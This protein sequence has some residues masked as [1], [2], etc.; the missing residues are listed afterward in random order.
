[1]PTWGNTDVANAKPKFDVERQ[2][3]EVIQ[4]ALFASANTTAN[5][6]TTIQLAY[7][8][9][10]GNNVANIGVAAGQYVYVAGQGTS[11]SG[12]SG[13]GYPGFFAS[14]NTVVSVSG[15]TVTLSANITSNIAVGTTIEFDKAIAYNTNKTVEVTYNQDT[16]LITA[17]RAA[18]T[19][20]NSGNYSAGWVH[21][22]KKTNNDGTIRY[23]K[24]T[25][26]ALANGTASNTSSG[27]TSWGG[28]VSGL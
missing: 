21:I 24:E 16:V 25:L 3:R 4:L 27:N 12:V 15:N 7:N 13:N 23:L 8:D 1:M 10:A 9:G 2:T 20:I 19:L 26:V 28:A 14:N 22:Q 17:T 11:T 18:N 5:G 6:T